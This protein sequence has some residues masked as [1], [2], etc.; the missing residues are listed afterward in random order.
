M[1]TKEIIGIFKER[2]PYLKN[3]EVNVEGE[4]GLYTIRF[5][6]KEAFQDVEAHIEMKDED[7]G[8]LYFDTLTL[9]SELL[10][11]FYDAG[12]GEEKH[13]LFKLEHSAPEKK[14][15]SEKMKFGTIQKELNFEAK[16]D[17]D[18]SYEGNVTD[19]VEEDL[20]TSNRIDYIFHNINKVLYQMD[21]YCDNHLDVRFP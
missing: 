11:N 17:K 12:E 4:E 7:S 20:K 5:N 21:E 15:N 1:N 2:V 16:L 8:Y 10:L 3:Y 13:L 9:E 6:K 19:I 14:T 18:F